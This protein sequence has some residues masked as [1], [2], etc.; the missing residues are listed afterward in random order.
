MI[1]RR[2]RSPAKTETEWSYKMAWARF[3]NEFK[4]VKVNQEGKHILVTLAR[5]GKSNALDDTMWSEIPQ[6]ICP[7]TFPVTKTEEKSHSSTTFRRCLRHWTTWTTFMRYGA[8]WSLPLGLAVH[9][10]CAY[11]CKCIWK[12]MAVTGRL[13]LVERARTFALE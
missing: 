6:V 2:Y 10:E 9:P 1:L 4:T 5:P 7:I 3:E 11:S 12:H 8:F 13:Y